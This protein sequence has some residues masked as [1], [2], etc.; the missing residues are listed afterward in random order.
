MRLRAGQRLLLSAQ[1]FLGLRECL[2]VGA[3]R[4][5][6]IGNVILQRKN[7]LMS[8]HQFLPMAEKGVHYE[9]ERDDKGEDRAGDRLVALRQGAPKGSVIH[10]SV[11]ARSQGQG[12]RG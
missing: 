4:V 8:L 10:G 3:E 1:G 5:L 12:A 7:L 2:L 11:R 6:H 9:R